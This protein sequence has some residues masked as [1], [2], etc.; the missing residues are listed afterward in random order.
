MRKRTILWLEIIA[1][2]LAII[3]LAV[4]LPAI[5]ST[6]QDCTQE[7]LQAGT[8][9]ASVSAEAGAGIL[10]GSVLFTIA[11]ILAT[12]AWI[13]ALVRSARMQ[14]W[15]WFVIILLFHGLGTLIYAIAG[16][17]DQTTMAAAYRAQGYPP[18]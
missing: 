7:Q 10:I 15:A 4:F 17:S 14:S 9:T 8:C 11:G 2:I 1:F 3:G 16:P 6:V 12:I 18:Q 13:I 5:F